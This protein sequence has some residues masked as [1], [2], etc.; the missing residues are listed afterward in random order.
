MINYVKEVEKE[1]PK[2]HPVGMTFQYKN[3]LNQA[4]Y[5]SPADWISPNNEGGYRDDPP[6]PKSKIVLSDTDH[7]WGIGGNS[8]W[9]WKS[10]FRGLNPIFMDPYECKVLTLSFDTAWVEPLRKSMGYTLQLAQKID[11]I[12]MIPKP[13][14][15]STTY[16]LANEG[17]EYLVYLPDTINVSV[18]LTGNTEPFL[19]EWFNTKNMETV[20][21]DKVNGGGMIEM[22]SPFNSKG[23]V[24]YLKRK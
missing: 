9:V 7:L 2:Q 4:L 22:T 20:T 11:L 8:Q 6:V 15:V 14:L 1:M 17:K 5:D 23:A 19:V 3:G 21:G 12:N 10:F 16:C 24:L 18:N 13:D